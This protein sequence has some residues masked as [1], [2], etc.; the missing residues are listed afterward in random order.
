MIGELERYILYGAY[1][2]PTASTYA[3]ATFAR[4]SKSTLF[5]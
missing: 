5:P 4:R 2:T 3:L 1:S